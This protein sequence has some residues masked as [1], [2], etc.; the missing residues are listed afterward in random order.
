MPL[1]TIQQYDLLGHPISIS[2]YVVYERH[3]VLTAGRVRNINQRHVVVDR[4][5]SAATPIQISSII[6]LLLPNQ[7]QVVA[8]EKIIMFLIASR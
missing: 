4:I 1:D 2:Q 8:D 6:D 3:A 7:V 5:L